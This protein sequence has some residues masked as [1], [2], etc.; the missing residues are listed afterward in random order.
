M[1]KLIIHG[2]IR[3]VKLQKN[4]KFSLSNIYTTEEEMVRGGGGGA[5][6]DSVRHVLTIAGTGGL[7]LVGSTEFCS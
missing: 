4:V 3:K 6:S 2:V 7:L 1:I 5:V